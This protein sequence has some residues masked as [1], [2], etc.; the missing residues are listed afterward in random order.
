MDD[1]TKRQ[2][3]ELD[4]QRSCVFLLELHLA[5]KIVAGSR[6]HKDDMFYGL[7]PSVFSLNT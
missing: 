3:F 4:F 2:A 7:Q 1:H 5:A 6:S